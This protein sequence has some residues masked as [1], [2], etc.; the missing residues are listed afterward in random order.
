MCN[1]ST[2][3][4]SKFVCMEMLVFIAYN[5][6]YSNIVIGIF[7]GHHNFQFSDMVSVVHS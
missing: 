7:E 2:T 4:E 3:V 5:Y 6:F 1:Y